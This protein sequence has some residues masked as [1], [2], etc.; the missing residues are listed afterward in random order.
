MTMFLFGFEEDL[1]EEEASG[2]STEDY[3][4]VIQQLKSAASSL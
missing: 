4:E 2:V 1:F 3:K